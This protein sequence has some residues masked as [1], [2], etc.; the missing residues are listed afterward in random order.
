MIIIRTDANKKIATGH[1]M[2]C[3]SIAAALRELG[4]QTAFACAAGSELSAA[5][6]AGF[7][8]HE[9]DSNY[10]RLDGELP[11]LTALVKKLGAGAVLVDSYFVSEKYLSGL[12]AVTAV[13]Y[14]DDLNAFR[15]PCNMLVNYN[16]YAEKLGYERQ[17]AAG[18]KLLLGCKYAPL[19]AQFAGLPARD[20]SA[21]PKNILVTAGGADRAGA[22][23]TLV[24]ALLFAPQLGGCTVH[25]VAGALNG[26][27][28]EL[29]RLA[30]QH[31]RVELHENVGE[32]SA[33][34]CRCEL[35]VSAAGSTLYELCACGTPTE[36]FTA[37]DNKLAAAR[38]FAARGL[39]DCAGDWRDGGES[40]AA[41]AARL[42][43][44]LAENGA[45]RQ[46]RSDAARVLVDGGGAKRLAQKLALLRQQ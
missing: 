27:T 34:M 42:A 14:M 40:C 18:T 1:L 10:D 29:R 38:E 4:V 11:Q 3:L 6:A 33:L 23:E 19:R 21:A 22:A 20:L 46:R 9:L 2:R 12:R 44:A 5:R 41:S 45:E 8:M 35:A 32:M 24:R 17:Y 16:C 25:V 36:I 39:M 43:T 7:A 30:A 26:H 13:A 37:A 15:Y 31:E 28:G